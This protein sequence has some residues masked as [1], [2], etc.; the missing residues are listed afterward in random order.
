MKRILLF[1]AFLSFLPFAACS[2]PGAHIIRFNY[3]YDGTIGGNSHWYKIRVENQ[4]ATFTLEDMQH[5]QLGEITD[6]VSMDFVKDLENLC[7]KHKVWKWDGYKKDNPFVCDGHGWSLYI[8]YDNDKS[9]DAYGMNMSPK[10]YWE[11]DRELHELFR[12]LC[13]RLLQSAA[14]QED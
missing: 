10:G 9:V 6:S 4:K 7:I 12:P 14:P 5:F 2:K 13:D 3:H 1:M 8:R 11:F